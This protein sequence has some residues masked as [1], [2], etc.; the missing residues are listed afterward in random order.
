MKK[1]GKAVEKDEKLK[2]P[3]SA[4]FIYINEKRAE[5]QEQLGTKDFGA[6]TKKVGEMWKEL[7]EAAK[8]PWN[9]KAK[10]QKDA[11]DKYIASPEGAAA[12]QAYK[13][14]VKDARDDVKGIKHAADGEEPA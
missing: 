11:Y 10:E 6:V 13:A 4:Y 7:S 3:Q 2:K 14:Q 12:L 1:A 9:D 8:K 5:V